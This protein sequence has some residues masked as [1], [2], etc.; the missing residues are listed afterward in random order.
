MLD[1]SEAARFLT[2]LSD[3]LTVRFRGR[4][5]LQDCQRLRVFPY[6]ASGLRSGSTG[7]W[8]R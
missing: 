8:I 2:A 7:Q 1:C 3:R 4:Q 6:A 5:A